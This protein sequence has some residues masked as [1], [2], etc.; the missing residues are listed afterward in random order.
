MPEDYNANLSQKI[1]NK[2]LL[3]VLKRELNMF[4]PKFSKCKKNK[5]EVSKHSFK[6]SVLPSGFPSISK[7]KSNNKMDMK[8]VRTSVSLRWLCF[9]KN[10]Y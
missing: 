8:S 4:K 2:L 9:T 5:I 7:M 10:R 3:K 1:R 6:L